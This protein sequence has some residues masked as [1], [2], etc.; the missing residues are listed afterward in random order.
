M[1]KFKKSLSPKLAVLKSRIMTELP[2]LVEGNYKSLEMK[3]NEIEKADS[4]EEVSNIL[5]RKIVD[6]VRRIKSEI[7]SLNS[8]LDAREVNRL[9]EILA[10]LAATKQWPNAALLTSVLSKRSG[11]DMFDIV[12]TVRKNYSV[13][14]STGENQIDSEESLEDVELRFASDDVERCLQEAPSD[15][16][17]VTPA[18]IDIVQDVLQTHFRRTFGNSK[19]YGKLG[20]AKF[21]EVKRDIHTSLIHLDTLPGVNTIRLLGTCL[22]TL[23]DPLAYEGSMELHNYAALYLDEHL[24]DTELLLEDLEV[25]LKRQF[26]SKLVRVLCDNDIIDKWVT[27][28]RTWSFMGWFT[29]DNRFC[30]TARAWLNDNDVRTGISNSTMLRSELDE[31]T[32]LD[33]RREQVLVYIGRRVL[34]RWFDSDE[35]TDFDAFYWMRGFH[36]RV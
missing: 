23:C 35:P 24:V 19:L 10:W 22:D 32:S 4:S 2:I 17:T 27:D 25:T 12:G 14:I 28:A 1:S 13:L 29:A 16:E 34:K 8:R 6:G 11:S 20:F 33:V 36:Q 3:L 31:L 7:E 21:L 18:E 26:G 30:D 9:N 5:E 15:R